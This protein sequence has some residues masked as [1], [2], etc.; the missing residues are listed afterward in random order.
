M[1][2]R[3]ATLRREAEAYC[4]ERSDDVADSTAVSY[5][6]RS[7]VAFLS[8]VAGV[9][10]FR[11]SRQTVDLDK[12]ADFSLNDLAGDVKKEL[13]AEGGAEENV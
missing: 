13:Q 6:S 1:Q 7:L 3:E 4:E 10:A 5:S 9:R 11:Q 8:P 2:V 12:E